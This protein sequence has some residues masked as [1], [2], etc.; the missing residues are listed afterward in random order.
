MH[1][2]QISVSASIDIQAASNQ[3]ALDLATATFL[4]RSSEILRRWKRNS[5]GISAQAYFDLF[6]INSIDV[7]QGPTVGIT[8]R[9]RY[10][11]LDFSKLIQV[12]ELVLHLFLIR[13][14]HRTES[15][16][17]IPALISFYHPVE[18][19]AHATR[20]TFQFR[21]VNWRE[22]LRSLR[23]GRTSGNLIRDGPDTPN[24]SSSSGSIDL[25]KRLR[26]IAQSALGTG[27]VRH[28]D[29]AHAYGVLICLVRGDCAR[30]FY[31]L[32]VSCDH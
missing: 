12:P 20:R 30:F 25:R 1:I 32:T 7:R 8:Y 19:I 26:A 16:G 27:S 17:F 2:V 9:S 18:A 21:L 6:G 23:S 28:A 15:R 24:G 5:L 11:I 10:I 31:T 4:H 14:T 13:R 29:S 22:A 3:E